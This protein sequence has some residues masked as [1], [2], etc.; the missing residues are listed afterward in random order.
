[1]DAALEED[2]VKTPYFRRY[3]QILKVL[4]KYGFEDVVAHTRFKGLNWRSIIPD[5]E[6]IPAM[7]YSRYERI[8]LVCEELGPTFIKFGQILSNRPDIIPKGLITELEKL[9]DRV[10]SV[11]FEEIKP[12]LEREFKKPLEEIFTF[13]DEKP[14]ASA[15]IAQV[16]LA[17][18]KRGAD[19]VLKIQKPG[20]RRSVAADIDIMRDLAKI[21]ERHFPESAVLQPVELVN[22]FEKAIKREMNF[23]T[24]AAS[25][26]RF[27]QNFSDDHR[28]YVPKVYDS[29]TTQKVICQEYIIGKKLTDIEAIKAAGMTPKE[30]AKIGLDLYFK[31]VFDFGFFHADPHPANIF[32][33]PD[34][35]LCFIDF[36][37]MGT[38]TLD[39]QF[40]LGDLMYYIYTEDVKKLADTVQAMARDN[41]IQ[42]REEFEQELRE[43]LEAAHTTSISEVELSEILEGLRKVMYDYKIKI[44]PNFHLLMRALIIIEGVGLT[45]FPDYNLM[46]EVQPYARKIMAKR[47]SPAELFKRFYNSMQEMGE[48]ILELP[49]DIRDVFMK[50]KQGKLHVEFEHKG[51]DPMMN[52]MDVVGNRV[53]FAIVVGSMILGSAI[54]IHSDIPPHYRN[55]PVL[56]VLAF[57]LAALFAV[58]LLYAIMKHGRI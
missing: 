22:T 43:F 41:I 1:M 45:I 37:M 17:K 46:E 15:S 34:G 39:D 23:V 31:Q 13:I 26:K 2:E 56:G 53:A 55:V 25:M 7:Q 54:V 58:R 20:I 16:H 38:L 47:Y 11:P 44:S 50:L 49:N 5:R 35:R 6:G 52:R 33:L 24:E 36:G 29:Y 21:I 51:L 40:I 57:I 12:K 4:V 3:R 30:A 10:P 18:L 14:I 9:Q 8:R 28:I 48:L 19:A 42:K 32:I 27:A